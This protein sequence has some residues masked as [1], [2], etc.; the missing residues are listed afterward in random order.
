MIMS[1]RDRAGAVRGSTES[2]LP[3]G[4]T[5]EDAAPGSLDGEARNGVA[6]FREP[7]E[8][9][10]GGRAGGIGVLYDLNVVPAARN[11]TLDAVFDRTARSL[12]SSLRKIASDDVEVAV[13]SI[14][15]IRCR[16]YLDSITL[17]AV[18]GVVQ[19]SPW[20]GRLL[21]V[22]GAKL[23]YGL[24][25]ATLGSAAQAGEASRERRAFTVIETG[26]ARRLVETLL[27]D[28][29]EA[30]SAVSP[31]T[32]ALDHLESIPH[33]ID[34]APPASAAVVVAMSVQLGD[35]TG[36]VEIFIPVATLEPVRE[37]LPSGS[38]REHGA[39]DEIWS[40][41][42]SQE[43]CRST[44]EL[45]A[46]LYE[47]RLKLSRVVQLGIGDTLLFE[48]GPDDPIELRCN[49]VAVAQGRVGRNKDRVAVKILS[50]I[51]RGG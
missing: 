22:V 23:V 35:I 42:L 19:A 12:K 48:S 34:I 17:P 50:F 9:G 49:G 47:E 5:G 46:V 51:D 28:A 38:P 29:A 13:A 21:V 4:F 20:G 3:D 32:L 44:V 45:E 1:R 33:F 40:R 30:L 14:G 43:V 8:A 2:G 6:G 37:L 18:L 27:A 16:A 39:P 41:H 25:E 24:L 11:P 31:V 15:T 36:T 7:A 26:V 10:P